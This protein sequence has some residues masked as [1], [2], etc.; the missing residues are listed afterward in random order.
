[1]RDRLV[2]IEGA[3][4]NLIRPPEGCAFHPRCPKAD[5]KCKTQPPTE[6]AGPGRT[7][8]CWHPGAPEEPATGPAPVIPLAE[9][10]ARRVQ[11]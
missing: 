5:V 10:R 6:V 8:A 7:V 4:P 9:G 3:P 2:S 1:M 11:S